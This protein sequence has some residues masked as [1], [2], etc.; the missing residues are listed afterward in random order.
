MSVRR[1]VK[2]FQ[3]LGYRFW[4]LLPLVGLGF[5]LIGMLI[6]EQ[7]LRQSDNSIQQLQAE[8]PSEVEE[9][10]IRLIQANVDRTQGKTQVAVKPTDLQA[11]DVEL[12][13]PTT[14]LDEVETQIAQELDISPAIVQRL[15]HYTI[16][17]PTQ[18]QRGS[19]VESSDIHSD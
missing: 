17:N 9:K 19:A 10:H 18:A 12:E 1:T 16:R 13:L 4:L 7:M 8:L 11:Q 6:T 15:T 5:W 3:V 2:P 14:R